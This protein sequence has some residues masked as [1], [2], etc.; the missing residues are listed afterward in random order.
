MSHTRYI[1]VLLLM[2]CALVCGAYAADAGALMAEFKD[3]GA[4]QPE[5]RKLAQE[6][7]RQTRLDALPAL[8]GMLHPKQDTDEFTRIG[9]LRMIAE[10][11]PLT[12]QAAQTLAWAAVMEKHLEVRREACAAIRQLQE[13][14]ALREVLRYGL[15]QD[16]AVRRS[17]AQALREI[18]DA[19]ALAGLVRAI[20]MPS[21][22]ANVGMPNSYSEP[23]MT[24]PLGP[25]GAR[26]PIFLPQQSISGVAT[27]IGSPAVDLLKEIAGKD[28][29]NLPFGWM[30]WYREKAA[31]IGAA[32]R[33]AYREHRSARELMNAP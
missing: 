4:P 30:N 22:N 11:A 17:A 3:L 6:K 16:A 28:F 9:V 8:L 12:D 10:F 13:D 33:E 29:G 20:P 18:D 7:V 26:M 1:A 24:L 31:Q 25:S 2:A 27:D 5:K 15:A 23:N 21:V 32:E 14:R 19:R